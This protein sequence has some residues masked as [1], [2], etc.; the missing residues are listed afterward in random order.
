M[1]RRE[2]LYKDYGMHPDLVKELKDQCRRLNT[3]EQVN[4]LLCAIKANEGIAPAL[5]YSLI[6]GASYDSLT[7]CADIPINRVDFYAYQRYCLFLFYSGAYSK[8]TSGG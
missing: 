2:M 7:V 3:E 4:L 8:E 1:K 6:S 5:Y